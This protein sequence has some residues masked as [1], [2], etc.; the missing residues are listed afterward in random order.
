M[1]RHKAKR[2]RKCYIAMRVT[3]VPYDDD[4]DEVEDYDPCNSGHTFDTVVPR[5]VVNMSRD[6]DVPS[7]KRNTKRE[8]PFGKAGSLIVASNDL[9][10]DSEHEQEDDPDGAVVENLEVTLAEE[11]QWL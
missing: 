10:T 8:G 9:D 5:T 3:A 6:I 11:A 4:G 2:F 7:I 1:R